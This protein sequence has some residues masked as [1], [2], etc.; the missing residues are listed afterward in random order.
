MHRPTHCRPHCRLPAI[1]SI[2]RDGSLPCLRYSIQFQRERTCG[3]PGTATPWDPG[4]RSQ[5]G[6]LQR[7][8]AMIVVECLARWI[9]ARGWGAGRDPGAEV[10]S[11]HRQEELILPAALR[12][13]RS[14]PL[15]GHPLHQ[16]QRGY[17]QSSAHSPMP[18]GSDTPGHWK[19]TTVSA[20][21]NNDR[22]VM[23]V[24]SRRS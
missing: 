10:L 23:V 1:P 2:S 20:R 5:L 22:R 13:A 7:P 12:F 16:R 6:N 15:P 8:A 24:S 3:R 21:S 9:L 17:A 4:Q 18:W 19:S 11:L 14:T